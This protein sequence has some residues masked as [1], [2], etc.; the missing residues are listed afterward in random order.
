MVSNTLSIVVGTYNRLSLLQKCIAALKAGV[1]TDCEII[2]IDAGSSD[3]TLEYLENCPGLR[4][5]KD[6]KLLGQ[7]QSLNRVM[8]TLESRYLCWLSDDNIIV[9]GVLD[10]AVRIL[11][12]DRA[13]G[14]VS[15]KVRDVDDPNPQR[16]YIGGTWPSGIMNCN[17]GMLPTRLFQKLGGFDEEFRDYGIDIDLT[18]RVLLAG[19]KVVLTREVAIHHHRNRAGASWIDRENRKKRLQKATHFYSDKYRAL[20]SPGRDGVYDRDARLASKGLRRIERFYNWA[21]RRGLPVERWL[22]VAYWD[23]RNLY[24]ARFAS[25]LD[26]LKNYLRD[27]YFEQRLPRRLVTEA[28]AAGGSV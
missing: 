23:W 19:Y 3:G 1:K 11:E 20:V 17:Q 18:T 9:S 12:R 2:V 6:E 15:L 21:A 22:R 8:R 16:T 26:F 24:L 7:A 4:L 10:R 5:V 27:Y 14:M 28:E 13:I 25:R